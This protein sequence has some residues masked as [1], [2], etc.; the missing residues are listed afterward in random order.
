M[1]LRNTPL[2]KSA[3]RFI[4]RLFLLCLCVILLSGT[5]LGAA[6]TNAAIDNIQ[7]LIAPDE[8]TASGATIAIAGT[9]DPNQGLPTTIKLPVIGMLELKEIQQIDPETG[10]DKGAAAYEKG[11]KNEDGIVTYEIELTETDGFI[12]LFSSK[13]G[14][15]TGGAMG[16]ETIIASFEFDAPNDLSFVSIGFASPTEDLVGAGDDSIVFLG[17]DAYGRE[18]YGKV[19]EDVAEGDILTATVAFVSRE[20]RDAA[21][22]EQEQAER[23][24]AWYYWFTT[25]LGMIASAAAI[26]LIVIV[27]I[28]VLL[29]RKRSINSDDFPD[30]NEDD[31]DNKSDENGECVQ[32]SDASADEI[33]SEEADL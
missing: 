16:G 4:S 25:P 9:I 21:L 1:Y 20:H 30:D 28:T 24:A 23:E 26:A 10:D 15:Y 17:H 6:P 33:L 14:L 3:S 18:V 5:V 22:A 32:N 2:L 7:I 13:M 31:T 12:A 19:F 27:I 11:S 8:E 29:Q